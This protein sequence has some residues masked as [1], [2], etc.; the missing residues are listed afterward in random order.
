MNI[1]LQCEML[2]TPKA[3]IFFS[4]DKSPITKFYTEIPRSTITEC[5]YACKRPYTVRIPPY[6]TV[7]C[8]ITW[9][10]ITIVYRRVRIRSNTIIYGEK[11]S[12]TE[13]V[14]DRFFLR[15]SPYTVK[16][17]ADS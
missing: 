6:T 16:K 3:V 15:I 2:F 10:R 9:S 11:G 4:I 14:N 1:Y 8:R 5:V 12:K 7:F 13:T 17:I